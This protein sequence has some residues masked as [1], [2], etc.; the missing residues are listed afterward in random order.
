MTVIDLDD[1]EAKAKAALV[2]NFSHQ[3]AVYA[4]QPETIIA[5]IR[6]ARAA[7]LAAKYAEAG[8]VPTHLLEA[9]KEIE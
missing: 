2:I 7:Q 6:V 3:K 5:L 1:L 9:L 8:D 4:Y